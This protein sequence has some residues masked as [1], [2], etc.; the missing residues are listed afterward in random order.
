MVIGKLPFHGDFV[1]RGVT[2]RERDL[3]DKWLATSM[4]IASEQLGEKFDEAFDAAPPWR[5]AWDEDGWT[6][7]AL[8]PS[9]DSSGRRFPLL[10]ALRNLREGQVEIASTLCEEAASEAIALRW[11]ADELAKAVEA[12]DIPLNGAHC[13]QGWWNEDPAEPALKEK[14]PTEIISHVLASAIGASA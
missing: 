3:L 7:G 14:A 2:G 11:N 10:V 13:V 6:A 5:F 4:A 8:V 12:P 1:A 9:V